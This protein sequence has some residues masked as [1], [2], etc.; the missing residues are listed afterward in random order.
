MMSVGLIF[1]SIW[2]SEDSGKRKFKGKAIYPPSMQAQ[3][4]ITISLG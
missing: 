4:E 3:T 1:V 2:D